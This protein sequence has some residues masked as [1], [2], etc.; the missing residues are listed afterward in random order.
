MGT[1]RFHFPGE[2][3]QLFGPHGSRDI[4]RF[5][6]R[7]HHSPEDLFSSGRALPCLRDQC[8]FLHLNVHT[9]HQRSGSNRLRFSGSGL[10]PETTCLRSICWSVDPRPL[11]RPHSPLP[12]T[13]RSQKSL[14][15][16]PLKY[17]RRPMRPSSPISTWVPGL[18]VKPQA[19]TAAS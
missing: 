17:R 15:R 19:L 5:I 13:L 8:S 7:P 6:Q 14:P 3:T 16:L 2:K 1:A 9:N 11:T 12:I 4:P 10:G 18:P